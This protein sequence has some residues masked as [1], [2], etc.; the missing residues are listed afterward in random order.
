MVTAKKSKAVASRMS[1]EYLDHRSMDPRDVGKLLPASLS[2]PVKIQKIERR[3]SADALRTYLAKGAT[4]SDSGIRLHM[5]GPM[6]TPRRFDHADCISGHEPIYPDVNHFKSVYSALKPV[7]SDMM[8]FF[9]D[10]G[11]VGT[12]EMED[13]GKITVQKWKPPGW[14]IHT[15]VAEDVMMGAPPADFYPYVVAVLKKYFKHL[16]QDL[17]AKSA[18]KERA[19][20]LLDEDPVD[21]MTGM[22]TMASGLETM[23]ARLSVLRSIPSPYSLSRYYDNPEAWLEALD[24]VGLQ[25]GLPRGAFYSSTL[26]TRQGPMKKPVTA[27]VYD[28]GGFYSNF[29]VTGLYSRTRFV[30][31]ASYPLN[32]ILSPLYTQLS[33]CRKKMLGL[34]HDDIGLQR[35]IASAKS[36]SGVPVT[37]DFSGMDTRITHEVITM[38]G[39]AC[40]DLGFAPFAS[41]MLMI[42]YDHMGLLLPPFGGQPGAWMFK[43]KLPW[44]SG[45]KLTS[46]LDTIYAQAVLLR[47]I[48]AQRPTVMSEWEND[49]FLFMAQGDDGFFVSK[50]LNLDKIAE[51]AKQ[52]GAVLEVLSPD[53]MFLK[54]WLPVHPDVPSISRS[55]ARVIQQTFFNEDRYSGIT[56]GDRP[57]AV[58]RLALIARME[59]LPAHPH[60]KLW[61]PK[62]ASIIGELGYVTRSSSKFRKDLIT[63]IPSPDPGDAQRI[64]DYAMKVESFASRLLS[65]AAFEPSA[66]AFVALMKKSGADI[67]HNATQRYRENLLLALDH[68][69]DR[70]DV[71]HLRSKCTWTK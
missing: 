64:M 45:F 71:T 14:F 18:S 15:P 17:V 70:N 35:S 42:M 12:M 38:I 32:F 55:F 4:Y 57:D 52:V 43:D 7:V 21:T 19:L 2:V 16:P 39:R 8:D 13:L 63:G 31:P 22:P 69:P 24:A 62:I 59:H 49:K 20:I 58:M 11:I 3:T 28:G 67:S 29:E 53:V 65:R 36:S 1:D 30:Y 61:W 46:E 56:G 33:G 51:S 5:G 34:W 9:A 60:F 44:M 6:G 25:I 10:K 48:H 68:V 41:K 40:K 50:D 66:A 37:V 27:W 47:A 23:P 54:K 26:A